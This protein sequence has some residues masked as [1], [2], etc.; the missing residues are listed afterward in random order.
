MGPKYESIRIASLR[1][2]LSKLPQNISL[3]THRGKPV[4]WVLTDKRREYT[5]DSLNGQKFLKLLNTKNQI[6]GELTTALEKW[7]TTY[8]FEPMNIY[9][10]LVNEAL[11]DN[12][13]F[14]TTVGSQNNMEIRQI[15]KSGNN[16]FRSKNELITTSVLDELGLPYKIEPRL[17]LEYETIYPDILFNAPLINYSAYIEVFGMM[18]DYNYSQR[19]IRKI[20]NYEKAGL[21]SD[22]DIIYL[23]MSNSVDKNIIKSRIISAIE[24]VIPDC[25]SEI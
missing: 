10:P 17:T 12:E 6:T 13:Y 23:F 18:N 7:N 11:F 1:R 4:I 21:V 3:G 2:E 20:T 24:N 8:S 5:L 16:A 25:V 19:T 15:L 22:R 9:M 14:D